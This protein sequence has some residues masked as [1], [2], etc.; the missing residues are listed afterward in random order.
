MVNR[1]FHVVSSSEE[2][3]PG[4]V[5][6]MKDVDPKYQ[7]GEFIIGDVYERIT[8][9][10]RKNV[11]PA[12]TGVYYN[13]ELIGYV[14]EELDTAYFDDL[15]LNMDT[16]AD[17]TFYLLDGNGAIITA[18]DTKNKRS[19]KTFVS[20][21]SDRNDFQKNGMR[22]TMR[23]IRPVMCA[24]AITDRIILHIIPTWKIPAGAS[25]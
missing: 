5:S 14:M 11:V 8:D 20:K 1:N 3:E 12:Y 7:T 22:S 15:R 6:A 13:N 18:G 23:K 16:L 21:S 4:T 25:V 9:D 24:T 10:G 17:G 19:L 2:Y